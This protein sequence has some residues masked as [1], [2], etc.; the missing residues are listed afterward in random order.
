MPWGSGCGARQ[1]QIGPQ[2]GCWPLSKVLTSIRLMVRLAT[3]F[4]QD[5]VVSR[6]GHPLVCPSYAPAWTWAFPRVPW[7]TDLGPN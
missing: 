3:P 6:M 5:L 4:F 7:V 2:G 1:G